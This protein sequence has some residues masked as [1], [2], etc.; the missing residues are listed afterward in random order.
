MPEDR[1]VQMKRGDE[2]VIKDAKIKALESF[3]RTMLLTVAEDVTL[4]GKLPPEM[5]E[6]AV[7]YI[8]ETTGG[9]IYNAEF[10]P[11]KLFRKTWK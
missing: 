6:M 11:F 9:N 7:N 4:K 10:A 8:V 3:D 5:D 1:L 2:I